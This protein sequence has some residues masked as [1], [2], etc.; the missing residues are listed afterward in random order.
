[1]RSLIKGVVRR[2]GLAS[3][4]ADVQPFRQSPPSPA[5]TSLVDDN[6]MLHCKAQY[7]QC[8][9]TG[10]PTTVRA[11]C[12]AVVSLVCQPGHEVLKRQTSQCALLAAWRHPP[13]TAR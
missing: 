13:E 4:S 2:C 7:G 6:V 5:A 9:R 11:P 12:L 10:I 8:V 1:M 3:R